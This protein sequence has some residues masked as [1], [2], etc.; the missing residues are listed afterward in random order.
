MARKICASRAE[1]S[2]RIT[3]SP[4]RFQGLGK[5]IALARWEGPAADC[6]IIAARLEKACSISSGV[7]STCITG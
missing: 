1:Q 6:A 3:A 5:P 7:T 4:S 2:L